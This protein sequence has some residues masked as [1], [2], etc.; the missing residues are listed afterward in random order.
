MATTAAPAQPE[1]ESA[2]EGEKPKSKKKMLLM[3]ALALALIAGS[4]GAWFAFS[5]PETEETATALAAKPAAPV[6]PPV[7]VVMD[8]FTVN[9]QPDG[10]FPQ[11]SFTL[12]VE[13]AEA[14]QT[15]KNYLPQVRS[16]LLMLLSS[17]QASELSTPDGK[18]KL[19]QEITDNVQQPFTEGLPPVKVLNVF[20]TAFVIQ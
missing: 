11:A 2:A 17:S 16:R 15:L 5:E 10:Q 12:Q 9:L 13:N 20:I 4:V 18:K 8:P 7:F 19:M 14:S 6:G 1:T 3:G